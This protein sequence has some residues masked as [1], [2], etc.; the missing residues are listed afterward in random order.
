M[1]RQL[2]LLL[3]IL[4]A[5]IFPAAAIATEVVLLKS[6]GRIEGELV[7]EGRQ[8]T[9]PVH[10]VT[11]SGL[12]LLFGPAQVDRVLVKT[13]VQR[14]YEEALPKVPNTP[15]GHFE[16]ARLC[17]E[18]GLSS[19][20]KFHLEQVIR[21]D[22]DHEPARLLLGYIRI[23][24]SWMKPDEW[25]R[26]RGYVYHEG[27]WRLP[28]EV[29][30]NVRDRQWELAS[31]EWRRKVKVWIDWVKGRKAAEGMENI[32]AIRD[33]AAAPALV[34]ALADRS[35]PRQLRLTC[36]ELLTRMPPGYS[37]DKL[38]ELAL[39]DPDAELRDKCLDEL[40]RQK[41]TRAL[42]LFTR[43]LKSK[44]NQVVN[45]AGYCL[46]RLGDPEA[47][48]PLIDALVTTHK[49]AITTGSGSPGGIGATFGGPTDGS[50]GGLGG[51]SFGTPKPKIVKLNQQ[52]DAVLGAL[53]SLNPGVNFGFDQ[54]RWREWYME[55]KTSLEADLR[56]GE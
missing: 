48:V 41:S 44:D 55:T 2:A 52:N 19:Q 22:P 46:Q 18:A 26:R 11:E 34:E 28:Q 53:V 25:M 27:R 17:Q 21:L 30:L 37:T 47:T 15:E 29:A 8:R 54:K 23:G 43:E 24:E 33:E 4:A 9:D 14:Q 10:I 42:A 45:R 20:R 13:D 38:I 1:I 5:G 51:F 50:G 36:L 40:H 3:G 56:R 32:R 7:N 12:K 35:L 49:Y 39:K 6:G 16:M 31:K